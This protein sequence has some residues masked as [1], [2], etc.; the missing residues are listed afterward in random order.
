MFEL[1]WIKLI[2]YFLI[3]AFLGPPGPGPLCLSGPT[4]TGMGRCL[5]AFCRMRS[6]PSCLL[7]IYAGLS[8]N[9]SPSPSFLIR[10]R[11]RNERNY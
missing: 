9:A 11:I 7:Y 6:L 1:Y 10:H 2:P 4:R 8:S 3:C 5:L